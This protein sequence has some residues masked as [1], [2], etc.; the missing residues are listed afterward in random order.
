MD[1]VILASTMSAQC[2][3]SVFAVLS[4]LSALGLISI[5]FISTQY[6]HAFFMLYFGT[7]ASTTQF[8]CSHSPDT[9]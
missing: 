8:L 4:S 3:G 2:C 5:I 1:R 6:L 9:K 7:F